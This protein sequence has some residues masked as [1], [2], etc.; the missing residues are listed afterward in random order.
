MLSFDRITAEMGVL[1]FYGTPVS[2]A[3]EIQEFYCNVLDQQTC[4]LY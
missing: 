1:M 4:Q 2:G 3:V